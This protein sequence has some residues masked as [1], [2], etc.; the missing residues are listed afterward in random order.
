MKPWHFKQAACPEN[1]V[2]YQKVYSSPLINHNF[3]IYTQKIPFC[4]KILFLCKYQ[5][6]FC[7]PRQSADYTITF[8]FN[9]LFSF[10]IKHNHASIIVRLYQKK[11][12]RTDF[13]FITKIPSRDSALSYYQSP[14]TRARWNV[15]FTVAPH[16]FK[17]FSC[18]VSERFFKNMTAA[19]STYLTLF[20]ITYLLFFL[21]V[22]YTFFF[23]FYFLFFF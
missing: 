8:P 21:S 15:S 22:S 11:R 23:I 6:F 20:Y 5:E 14:P 16:I 1:H 13:Q 3:Y 12:E 2:Y 10:P 19:G 9:S 4:T 18:S 7:L 17:H